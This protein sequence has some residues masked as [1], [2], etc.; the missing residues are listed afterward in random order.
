MTARYRTLAASAA[1]LCVFAQQ[2]SAAELVLA[3]GG[4]SDYQIVAGDA[5]RLRCLGNAAERRDV[6]SRGWSAAHPTDLEPCVLPV[7]RSGT[8]VFHAGCRR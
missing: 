8:T 2:A 4:K 5:G 6:S 3:D 7:P 1:L